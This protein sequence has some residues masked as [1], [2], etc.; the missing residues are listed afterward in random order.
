MIIKCDHKR[1]TD[2]DRRYNI[3]EAFISAGWD[4]YL[5]LFKAEEKDIYYTEGYVKLYDQDGGV[6]L[7]VICREDDGILLMPFIR[8]SIGDNFDFETPYGYGGPISNTK[9]REWINAALA[10]MTGLFRG[11]GYICGFYRFHP[12]LNNAEI[13]KDRIKVIY[14]RKTVF[15]DLTPEEEEIWNTQINAKCR[16]KI[17]KAEKAG[18][19]FSVEDDPSSLK[20]FIKLYNGTMERL[21]A[22]DFYFFEDSYYQN[23]EN[24]LK[25]EYFLGTVRSEGEM[26][27][28]SLFMIYGDGAHYH[29][30]GS[31]NENRITGSNNLMLWRAAGELRKR[32]VRTFHLGGG[33]DSMEDNSLFV[34]KSSFSK[35]TAD[36]YIGRSVFNEDAYEKI[37]RKWES[38]NPEKVPLYGNRLLKY[39]Y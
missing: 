2:K 1:I 17:R 14:D 30:A 37:C 19:V 3:V 13:C 38:E 11:E 21:S 22:D 29:L 39:R 12:L 26:I 16:N 23:F 9:D 5:D 34:F 36:Y 24:A 32:G 7:C 4:Q 31:N 6:P 20:E 10:A 8:K 35:H 28:A 25:G 18:L 33:S 27:C 15:M